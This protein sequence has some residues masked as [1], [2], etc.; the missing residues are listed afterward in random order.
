MQGTSTSRLHHSD[1]RTSPDA[2][3]THQSCEEPLA[4]SLHFWPKTKSTMT[5]F[6]T[7]VSFQSRQIQM[8]KLAAEAK[9]H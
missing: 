5:G 7:T 2:H 6:S 4:F 8:S 1:T 3:S 9:V